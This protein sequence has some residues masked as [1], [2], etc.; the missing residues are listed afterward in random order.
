MKVPFYE[1]YMGMEVKLHMFRNSALSREG[2]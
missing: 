1:K 2:Q